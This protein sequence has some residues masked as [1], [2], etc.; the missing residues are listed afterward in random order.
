MIKLLADEDVPHPLIAKLR[1][2]GIDIF[3]V[4][5]EMKSATDTDVFNKA[6]QQ[7]RAILTFDSDY[8]QLAQTAE[9]HP[10]ILLIT[11]RTSYTS[12][13]NTLLTHLQ[14]LDN[15]D[16]ANEILHISP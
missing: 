6:Q 2:K 5:E 10:G 15:E 9:T 16:I 7:N 13:V 4:D 14:T 8:R 1:A 11:K 12:I 3:S